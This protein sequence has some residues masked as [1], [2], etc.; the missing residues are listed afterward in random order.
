MY[1]GELYCILQAHFLFKE[2]SKKELL[3]CWDNTGIPEWEQT[4]IYFPLPLHWETIHL[5]RKSYKMCLGVSR[6]L[7]QRLHNGFLP[8]RASHSSFPVYTESIGSI[9]AES[10]WFLKTKVRDCDH[11]G[12]KEHTE[13][14][15]VT[16]DTTNARHPWGPDSIPNTREEGGGRQSPPEVK[17]FALTLVRPRQEKEQYTLQVNGRDQNRKKKMFLSG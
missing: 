7:S 12:D 16:Q 6:F 14:G 5:T 2:K 11:Q 17:P 10:P 13:M 9:H 1:S 8:S 3:L 15:S 4:Q